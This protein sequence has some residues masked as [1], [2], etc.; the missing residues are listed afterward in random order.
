M[1]MLGPIQRTVYVVTPIHCRGLRV[2]H[3]SQEPL[4]RIRTLMN[5]FNTA[6]AEGQRHNNHSRT[7]FRLGI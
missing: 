3:L 4:S 6:P 5:Q 1:A 2:K 7:I